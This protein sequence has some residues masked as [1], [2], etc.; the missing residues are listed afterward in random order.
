MSKKAVPFGTFWQSFSRGGVNLYIKILLN[1]LF[2]Y[3]NIEIEGY[4]VEKFINLCISKN[5]LLWNIKRTKST[6]VYSNIGIKDFKKISKVAKNTKCKVKIKE[7][8]GLPFVFNKYKKRKIFIIFL[9]FLIVAIMLLSNFVWNIEISGN[10]SINKEELL[11][12]LEEN[13]LKIGKLKSK[14][15]T[16][17]IVDKMRLE[18]ND[19]AW[20][21]IEMK[22][23]NAIVKIVEADKKPDIIDQNDYCS[24]IASKPRNYSKSKCSRWYSPS[25]RRGCSK[26]RNNISRRMARR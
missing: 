26:S 18:R 13:G 20:I 21:G 4:F 6:L 3:L 11:S 22:G 15:E 12:T 17:K 19:L 24:I 8:K 1:Y 23:T 7:K 25:K 5:I 10:S 14:I 9:L 16:K 2:G